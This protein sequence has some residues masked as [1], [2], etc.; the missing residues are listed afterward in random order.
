MRVLIASDWKN[1]N[2]KLTA[3][4]FT[5]A[6]TVNFENLAFSMIKK[7]STVIPRQINGTIEDM[8]NLSLPILNESKNSEENKHSMFTTSLEPG[9]PKYVGADLK[10]FG[11]TFTLNSTIID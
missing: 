4:Y 10:I 1:K 2:R 5:C 7:I 3:V 6:L 11:S 8:S 9:F